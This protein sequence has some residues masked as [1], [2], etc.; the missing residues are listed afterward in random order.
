MKRLIEDVIYLYQLGEPVDRIATV[1][2][3]SVE[4]VKFIIAEYGDCYA[5]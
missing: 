3:L 1:Y 5:V 4:D 2:E